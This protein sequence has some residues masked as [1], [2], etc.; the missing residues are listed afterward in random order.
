V[1]KIAAIDCE[2]DPFKYGAVI[3]PFIW[4]CYFDGTFKWWRTF[5]ELLQW[6]ADKDEKIVV[7]A[8]NGGRFDYMFR[9]VV[10]QIPSGSDLKIISGRLA[11]FRI[12]NLEFRDSLAAV[13]VALSKFKKDKFSY[14][15]LTKERRKR[16]W[17]EIVKYL[18]ADC[19]NLH[20]LME[21]FLNDY[22]PKL[23][24]GGASFWS[25]S[26]IEGIQFPKSTAAYFRDLKPYYFGGRV[27][28][29][30]KGKV[31]GTVKLWDI[32][33]AYPFAMLQKHPFGAKYHCSDYKGGKVPNV[34]CLDINAESHGA[35]PFGTVKFGTTFPNDGV[36]RDFKITG[37]EYNAAKDCGLLGK[38]PR[39][40]TLYTFPVQQSL[41]KYINHHYAIRKQAPDGSAQ[42]LFSKLLMNSCY[43]K[44]GQAGDEYE[45]Y[46]LD[47]AEN[48]ENLS[49]DGWQIR[50]ELEDGRI[51]YFRPEP[52][53]RWRF[54]DVGFAL[55]VTG[56]VRATILRN[57]VAAKK[58]KST[59]HYVDTDGIQTSGKWA[60]KESKNL[61]DW[62]L[63]AKFSEMHYGGKK[64]YAGKLL[65]SYWY[66]DEDTGRTVKWKKAN[67]GVVLT[68]AQIVQIATDGKTL[69]YKKDSPSMGI[70]SQ[71][72]YIKRRVKATHRA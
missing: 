72:K 48:A 14:W 22:G 33:S 71:T 62:K 7:Y 45:Q 47:E 8:H 32:N 10:E 9:E 65:K 50:N 42:K 43:G 60:P 35:F 12:G 40:S 49:L 67:K 13:P 26:E 53:E 57:M 68:A 34:S 70:L 64:M 31:P 52:K 1:R 37:H 17:S 38:A 41:A 55:S 59:V 44:T 29:L 6:L 21:A 23:T 19:R 58:A 30:S 39:I 20:E 63:E 4:G 11:K 56:C 66:K 69:L 2:T 61:G 27:Q 54:Y 3:K 28:C 51:V 16:Y 18:E 24:L 36:R 25:A 46:R 15:K 5:P